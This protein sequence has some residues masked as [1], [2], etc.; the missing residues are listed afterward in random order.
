M[1][2]LFNLML[3]MTD[4]LEDGV[5]DAMSE[6]GQGVFYLEF[7]YSIYMVIGHIVLLNLLIAMLN[8]SYS[9]VRE[10]H[11]VTWRVEAVQ[12]GMSLANSFPFA[13]FMIGRRSLAKADLHPETHG[14]ETPKDSSS[15]QRWFLTLSDADLDSLHELQSHDHSDDVTEAYVTK[16][17]EL[18]T[19]MTGHLQSLESSVH[20]LKNRLGSQKK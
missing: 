18:E 19:R 5:E 15:H 9:A 12:L 2:Y 7:L 14:I 1:F 17:V 11:Q 13:T 8:D 3:G 20:D 4:V 16:M 6:S 10:V